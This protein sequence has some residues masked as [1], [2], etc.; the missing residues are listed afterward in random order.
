M[1]AFGW[2]KLIE[3]FDALNGHCPNCW[4]NFREKTCHSFQIEIFLVFSLYL[5]QLFKLM[6]TSVRWQLWWWWWWRRQFLTSSHINMLCQ[7]VVQIHLTFFIYT[8]HLAMSKQ[9]SAQYQYVLS[10]QTHNL[11][12]SPAI[13]RIPPYSTC[14]NCW[15]ASSYI[16]I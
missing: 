12:P 4:L 14:I 10:F 13:L 9:I 7:T 8:P 5:Q 16:F 1:V 6:S 11:K 15:Q 3:N 2:G